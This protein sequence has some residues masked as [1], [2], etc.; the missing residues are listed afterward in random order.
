MWAWAE[1][2]SSPTCFEIYSFVHFSPP[3]IWIFF[4]NWTWNSEPTSISWHGIMNIWIF[5]TVNKYSQ[6]FKSLISKL[7]SVELEFDVCRLK[8]PPKEWVG[9]IR[10]ITFLVAG[11][12][13]YTP[14]CVCVFVCLP[15]CVSPKYALSSATPARYSG[16][17][18]VSNSSM[19]QASCPTGR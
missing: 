11:E 17:L 2:S 16:S 18:I 13:L 19:P 4:L 5:F 1:H 12:H 6:M 9:H 10:Q 8:V 15:F 14:L 3:K 7:G